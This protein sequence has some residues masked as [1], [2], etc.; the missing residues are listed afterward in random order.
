M[1]KLKLILPDPPDALA[2]R[3]DLEDHPVDCV[4]KVFENVAAKQ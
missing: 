2:L 1:I 3:L 4:D